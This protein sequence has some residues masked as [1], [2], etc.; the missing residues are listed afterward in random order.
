M[1]VGGIFESLVEHSGRLGLET[2]DGWTS[3]KIPLSALLAGLGLVVTDDLL[4]LT[5]RA[6]AASSPRYSP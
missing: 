2:A 4:F 6:M 1:H 5:L 3:F